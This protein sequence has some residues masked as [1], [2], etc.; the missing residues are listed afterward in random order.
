MIQKIFLQSNEIN[1][2]KFSETKNILNFNDTKNI[3]T[4]K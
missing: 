1:Y 4:I 2:E 3:F